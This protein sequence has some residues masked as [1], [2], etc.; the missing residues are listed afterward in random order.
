MAFLPLVCAGLA[1]LASFPSTFATALLPRLMLIL[2]S[3][4]EVAPHDADTA[5]ATHEAQDDF[6][7]GAGLVLQSAHPPT[8]ACAGDYRARLGGASFAWLAFDARSALPEPD[9]KLEVWAEG[10]LI[11][12]L[13]GPSGSWPAAPIIVSSGDVTLRLLIPPK[14]KATGWGF[15]CW[16]HGFEPSWSGQLHLSLD[17]EMGVAF[18]ASRY[19]ATLVVGD[20]LSPEERAHRATLQADETRHFRAGGRAPPRA[21]LPAGLMQ[22]CARNR[23]CA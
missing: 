2:E 16:V 18:L 7:L 4:H 15:A 23:A 20:P 8:P 11:H 9:A 13:A 14:S 10:R 22:V 1:L 3:L 6:E 17:C 5:H 12:T 19:M 21:R